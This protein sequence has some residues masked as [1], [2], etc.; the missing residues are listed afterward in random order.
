MLQNCRKYR[1]GGVEEMTVDD[2]Y[3]DISN[4]F[5]DKNIER[6]SSVR[7]FPN[8]QISTICETY[9]DRWEDDYI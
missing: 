5:M 7:Y 9:D 2:E 1:N 6:N 8:R 4:I 3:E